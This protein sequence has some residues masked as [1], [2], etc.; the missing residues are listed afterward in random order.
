[1]SR[2]GE[3]ILTRKNVEF[4]KVCFF[5]KKMDKENQKVIELCNRIHEQSAIIECEQLR[6]ILDQINQ[7][8]ESPDKLL[9]SDCVRI[10]DALHDVDNNKLTDISILNHPINHHLLKTLFNILNKWQRRDLLNEQ[11]SQ[12]FN[13][14]ATLIKNIIHSKNIQHWE[15]EFFI[16]MFSDPNP[17]KGCIDNI[18]KHGKYINDSNTNHLATLVQAMG[19][20]QRKRPRLMD[21]KNALKLLESIVDCLS[22]QTYI[23]QLHFTFLSDIA[24]NYFKDYRHFQLVGETTTNYGTSLLLNACPLY[25]TAYKGEHRQEISFKLTERMLDKFVPFLANCTDKVIYS[26][27]HLMTILVNISNVDSCRAKFNEKANLISSLIRISNAPNLCNTIQTTVDTDDNP[28]NLLINSTLTLLYNLTCETN[29]LQL[30]K[31]IENTAKTFLN[32]IKIARY[33]RIRLQALQIIA[34][35]LNDDDIK[36]LDSTQF[37]PSDITLEFLRFLRQAIESPTQRYLG[38]HVYSLLCNLKGNLQIFHFLNSF[39]SLATT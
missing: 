13:K 7:E 38:V 31:S 28:C 4:F 29:I 2:R 30:L 37:N 15:I 10:C 16:Q 1:M 36:N 35:I 27:Y 23:Q 6:E 11:E 19:T 18:A 26:L 24:N 22:S 39:F 8:V 3:H 21:D 32:L 9:I 34:V 17:I 25:F 14:T 5:R 12:I 20:L 33:S